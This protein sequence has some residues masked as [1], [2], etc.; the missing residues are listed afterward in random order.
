[1]IGVAVALVVIGIIF[2]FVIPWVG[3]PVG[4]VGLILFVVWLLGFGR[5]TAT[6]RRP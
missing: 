4:I 6:D 3:I 5:R 1:M 2:L